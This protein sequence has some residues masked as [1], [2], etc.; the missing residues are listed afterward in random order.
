MKMCNKCQ[1]IWLD[2][3]EGC[4]DCGCAEFEPIIARLEEKKR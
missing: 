2:D 4:A 1:R 3:K